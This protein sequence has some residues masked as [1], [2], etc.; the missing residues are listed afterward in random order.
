MTFGSYEPFWGEFHVYGAVGRGAVI[1]ETLVLVAGVIRVFVLATAAG[2]AWYACARVAIGDEEEGT[3]ACGGGKCRGRCRSGW[4]RTHCRLSLAVV[5]V[6]PPHMSHTC[7]IPD[8]PFFIYFNFNSRRKKGKKKR[9]M[10]LVIR[11]FLFFCH[12]GCG[13]AARRGG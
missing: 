8:L 3:R 13:G 6:E 2:S 1:D 5:A 7:H 11:S 9:R 10:E 4:E 12:V